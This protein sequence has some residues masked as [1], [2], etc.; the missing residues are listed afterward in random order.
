[1]P[2]SALAINQ[3]VQSCMNQIRDVGGGDKQIVSG[4]NDF[5]STQ[6]GKCHRNEISLVPRTKKRAASYNQGGGIKPGDLRFSSRF[7]VAINVQGIERITLEI[8]TT[9][10]PV[11][12]KVGRERK[13]RDSPFSACSSQHS[14]A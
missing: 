9:F 12:N 4:C 2:G 5:P 7:T 3:Q 1:M 13:Q 6:P 14:G 11:E 8:S 10:F